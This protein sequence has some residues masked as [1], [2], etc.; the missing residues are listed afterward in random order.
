MK[1]VICK[2][3]TVDEEGLVLLTEFIE[4]GVCEV[5]GSHT[6]VWV[7][8]YFDDN[9]EV[10]G[11]AVTDEEP[12]TYINGYGTNGFVYPEWAFNAW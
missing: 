8:S 4:N 5:C 2:D 1:K 7:R 10:Q 3:C 6:E 12:I 9:E 11:E